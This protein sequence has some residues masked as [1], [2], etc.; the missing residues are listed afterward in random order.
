MQVRRA[1]SEGLRRRSASQEGA[2]AVEHEY[3]P[4]RAY[5]PSLQTFSAPAPQPVPCTEVASSLEVRP[6]SWSSQPPSE[7][8]LI[9]HVA[10]MC[11]RIQRCPAWGRVAKNCEP[12]LV[13]GW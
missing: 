7:A 12:V 6:H 13:G 11:A 8:F 1:G 5:D 3:M 9:H 2:G 4:E 10:K